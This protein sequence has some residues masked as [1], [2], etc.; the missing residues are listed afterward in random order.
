MGHIEYPSF[1]A[2]KFLF[3][4]LSAVAQGNRAF[5]KS[6]QVEL[7]DLVARNEKCDEEKQLTVSPRIHQRL[8]VLNLLVGQLHQTHHLA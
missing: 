5:R 6:G 2:L 7:D 1:L 4:L 8:R 3:P